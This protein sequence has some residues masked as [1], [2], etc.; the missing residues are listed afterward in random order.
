[1][2]T[3]AWSR[4]WRSGAAVVY[5][6]VLGL[7]AS[8]TSSRSGSSADAGHD[9]GGQTDGENEGGTPAPGC[10]DISIVSPAA[11]RPLNEIDDIDGDQCANGFQY[12]VIVA[13]T[14]P[15]GTKGVLYAG[16]TQVGTAEVRGAVLTFAGVQ[17]T[18]NGESRL[19]VQ[20][21][22][23]SCT[24]TRV[25]KVSCS[26]PTCQITKPTVSPT[27]PK[28]NGVPVANGGDRVSADGA[29]YQVAVEVSTSVEDGQPVEL[30]IDD[31]PFALS[32]SAEGGKAV[33]AGVTLTP[34]GSHTLEAVCRGQSGLPGRSAKATY[35][36]DTT[37]PALTVTT[38]AEGQHFPDAET[39]QVCA[40][41]SA[42]DAQAL[43]DSLGAAA[44]K[45]FCARVGNSSPTCEA[46][47]G[48]G[49][50]CV[51]LPCPGGP[52]FDLRVSLRDAAGNTRTETVKSVSCRSGR[53]GVEIIAPVAYEPGNVATNV[54]AASSTQPQRDQDA[55]TP[56]AQFTVVA[57]T[58]APNSKMQLLVGLANETL[59]EASDPV[60]VTL[61]DVSDGCPAG[62][63]Y[64]AEFVN[65]TLPESAEDFQGMLVTPTRLVAR[66]TDESSST[67]ES[68]PVDVWVDSF[69]PVLTL[70]SPRCGSLVQRTGATTETVLLASGVV[71]VTIRV[72]YPDMT[73][74][75][76]TGQSYSSGSVTVRFN[77]VP[78]HYGQNRV[79]ASI[80]EPSGNEAS[81]PEDCV[82]TVG[83]PPRVTWGY[84]TPTSKLNQGNDARAEPGWQGTLHVQTD[85]AGVTP[86]PTVTFAT[87]VGGVLGEVEVDSNGDAFLDVTLP[88]GKSVQISATTSEVEG[89]GRG[90]ATVV[91]TV[92]TSAPEPIAELQASVPEH[93]RR[94]TTFRLAWTAPSDEGTGI[95]GY[96]V[97]MSQSP[98]NDEASFDAAIPV[99]Y[100]G[101][102][103][104]PGQPDGMD[105][106]D[107]LI[108]R[109]YYFAVRPVDVAG[110]RGAVA[111]AGPVRASFKRLV[112]T[113]A[114]GSGEQFGR[115]VDGSTDLN[116]DGFADLIVG[117]WAG[118]RVYIYFGSETGYDQSPSVEIRG[119]PATQFGAFVQV[120]GDID[121]DGLPELAVG[122]PSEGPGR[123]YLFK[124]RT[125]WGANMDLAD[126]AS[127][128]TADDDIEPKFVQAKLGQV[129]A[130]LGDFDGDGVN[131]FAVAAPEY[132][133]GRGYVAVIRG[134]RA[135][136]GP[137]PEQVSLTASSSR[138]LATQGPYD[139]IGRLGWGVTSLGRF[140]P[141]VGTTMMA[142]ALYHGAPPGNSA[143]DWF[144]GVYAFAGK[145][146]A[147]DP[148]DFAKGTVN[149]RTAGYSIAAIGPLASPMAVAYSAPGYDRTDGMVFIHVGNVN[150]GPFV[151]S[152]TILKSDAEKYG[153]DFNGNGFGSCVFSSAIPGLEVSF[154]DHKGS[155]LGSPLPDLVI[156]S[157][158]RGPAPADP[159]NVYIIDGQKIPTLP[160]GDVA[161]VAD[162]VV[163]LPDDWT[164]NLGC[165]PY[166]RAIRDLN[167]D[168]YADLAIGQYR[169]FGVY[170]GA[171]LVL[172]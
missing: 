29:P 149:Y 2:R 123:V 164:E 93:L 31:A 110:N 167:N 90:V 136:E 72:T 50:A 108:E 74:E 86:T 32:A 116:Q 40:V 134:V 45:N 132:D 62:K 124:G 7:A 152:P 168:G 100:V 115:S 28:L 77:A 101:I 75:E 76:R 165:S 69:A 140:Y 125:S 83:N 159:A 54:L 22:G 35:E 114:G 154:S 59:V 34:D 37:P 43:P 94:Q 13:T 126:V 38:P 153:A 157:L 99:T 120:V 82:V 57:C 39:F 15:E 33:F 128:I 109:D 8:C 61:A 141:G 169:W 119:K 158:G 12:D 14:A 95:Q 155:F 18:A 80:A 96:D 170:P 130:R 16:N 70:N 106:P 102:P 85:L 66:V 138:Y 97:R 17:L 1:M 143:L 160:S 144:G 26:V 4:V 67:G 88:E 19:S 30:I 44:Q 146:D 111:S 87:N 121:G 118:S 46:T 142:S 23:E 113:G 151:S 73:F 6:G 25:V 53:P 117:A 81:L 127:V 24:A 137:F 166:S 36:V 84:P 65:V 42:E 107:M 60:D 58:D 92:D 63:P 162:V 11:N 49:A 156:S 171:V 68:P 3:G 103:A 105:I 104:Q 91:V 52:P 21:G 20:V 163:P 10:P 122:A 47:D 78:F 139:S 172:W 133:G 48:D 41:T 27:H 55:S 64:R 9:G 131:D 79:E 5:L 135:D 98:I 112:L 89:R 71:P 148:A 147:T 150:S 145:L 129:L 56:G 161:D 51:E